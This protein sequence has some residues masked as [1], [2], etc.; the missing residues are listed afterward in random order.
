MN[1][2]WIK[3]LDDLCRELKNSDVVF[4]QIKEKF[5]ELR[6][7]YRRNKDIAAEKYLTDEEI[8]NLILDA[9]SLSITTCEK[10]GSDNAASTKYIG[11][12]CWLKT[13]CTTCHDKY[14]ETK[15]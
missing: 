3:I 7:Y 1:S 4:S 8:D 13:L 11:K 2:G 12:E 14:S 15:I 5:G 9:T 6:V 10:C